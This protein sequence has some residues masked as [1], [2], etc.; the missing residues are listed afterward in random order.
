MESCRALTE[1]ALASSSYKQT[2]TLVNSWLAEHFPN[3]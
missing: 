2:E 3:K 1:K